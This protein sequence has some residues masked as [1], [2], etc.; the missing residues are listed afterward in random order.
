MAPAASTLFNQG[1]S[2]MLGYTSEEMI[3]KRTPEVIHLESE[4]V[5]RG[6]ELSAQFGHPV[7]GFEVF[8]APARL[9]GSEVRDWTYVAKDGR[10]IPVSLVVTAVFGKDGEI[11]GFLGIAQ[12][13]SNA[14]RAEAALKSSEEFLEQTG[15]V[16]GVGGWEL[17]LRTNKLRHTRQTRLIHEVDPDVEIPLDEALNFYD[18]EYRPVIQQA[19]ERSIATGEPWDVEAQFITAKGK[20][21]WVR[22]IGHAELQDGKAVRLYG[23]FQDITRHKMDEIALDRERQRLA[24]VITAANLGA[25]EWDIQT[26]ELCVNERW[27]EICGY[28]RADLAPVGFAT[29]QRLVHPDDLA[30][31]EVAIGRHV[32]G[33]SPTYDVVFRMRHKAG[34]WVWVRSAGQIIGRS[35]EGEALRMYGTHDDI[36]HEKLREEALR[37][38][39]ARLQDANARAENASRAKGDFLANMSHEIRTPLNAIIGMTDLLEHDPEPAEAR[40]FLETIRSSG[41]SLLE[42]INDIL[43]LSKIEAGQLDLESVPFDLKHCVEGSLSTIAGAAKA[44]GLQTRLSFSPAVPG[45]VTGDALRL[46]QVLVNLLSNAVK[47]TET[48]EIELSVL[49]AEG[50]GVA[51]EVR[52]TGIGIKPEDHEKLFRN[53]SQVDTSTSRRYGGTGLGLAITQRLVSMM[54]GNIAVDSVSGRGSTFRVTLP[55]SSADAPMAI[56]PKP[57]DDAVALDAG[58]AARFPMRILVAEDNPINQRVAAIMLHRLGYDV[59][60]ASHGKEAL[61]AIA[62]SPVDMIFMDVQMPVLDGLKA[63]KEI[64]ARYEGPARPWIT[65]ITA[66][67]MHGERETCLAMG[68]DDYLSKPVRHEQLAEAIKRA[69]EA[70]AAR[71]AAQAGS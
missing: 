13:V 64:R 50:G 33:E 48:G 51:F 61:D 22:A 16:A 32:R 37:D 24:N 27:A 57:A 4:V 70:R 19:I 35:P 67:A 6:E 39:N 52:D 43:D 45:F 31:A 63:T 62:A 68:M 41:S 38:A 18:P 25:W 15:E 7:A 53:F 11:T 23:T 14:R 65:A 9:L 60:L 2:N 21:L 28:T 42:L 59:A 12:D 8:A 17:D 71:G 34:H 40:E 5:A 58:F 30:E 56:A 10:L 20:R 55:L 49:P 46:R 54:G 66:N 29:W 1:A 44:R 69:F 47:F 3:G 36:T 26:G